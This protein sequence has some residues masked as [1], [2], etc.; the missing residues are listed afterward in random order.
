MLGSDDVIA[1]AGASDLD[2]SCTFYA[3]ILGLRMVERNDFAGVFDANGTMLRV[4]AVPHVATGGYTV[5]GWRVTDI[6]ATV[7]ELVG[8]GVAFHHYDGMHQDELGIWTTPGG[9]RVAW[10]ADPDDNVLSLSQ[11]A[12]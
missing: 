8:R 4:T 11:F 6:A 1:F 2:R 7:N 3:E 5:L 10:F 9:V 12:S